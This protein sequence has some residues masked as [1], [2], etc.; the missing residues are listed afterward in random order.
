MEETQAQK[1]I[2]IATQQ[3]Q[4]FCKGNT[5]AETLASLH[6]SNV[7]QDHER[8]ITALENAK[9]T[10]K[11]QLQQTI[12]SQKSTIESLESTIVRL[13]DEKQARIL[14]EAQKT[15]SVQPTSKTL[16]ATQPT[17]ST[18][19][20]WTRDKNGNV[21]KAQQTKAYSKSFLKYHYGCIPQQYAAYATID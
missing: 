1:I 13:Q 6:S 14:A 9:D 15:Y 21:V 12:D 11:D 3:P 19:P 17:S 8:R 18:Q 7:I 10:T 20:L 4:P 5:L 16:Y 2:R